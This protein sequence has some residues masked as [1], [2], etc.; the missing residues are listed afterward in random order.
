[1]KYRIFAILQLFVM[2]FY[3]GRPILPYIEY[4]VFKDYIAKNLCINRDKPKSC[5]QGKCHLKKQLEK[6]S[7]TSDTENKSSNKK[8]S[9]QEV[10]VW[11][12]SPVTIPKANEISLHRFA[13]IEII[14]ASQVISSIFVPPKTVVIS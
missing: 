3:L 8:V 1:M 6:S 4:A 12:I 7:E 2:V 13:S 9:N 10:S 5:C 14:I 11:L